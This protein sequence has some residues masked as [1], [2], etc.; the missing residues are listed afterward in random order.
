M[1][2]KPILDLDAPGPYIFRLDGVAWAIT[3]AV[4]PGVFDLRSDGFKYQRI[5]R[6]IELTATE[7]LPAPP[8][9]TPA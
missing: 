8:M 7:L 6:V 9:E 2:E 4:M 1:T 5:P 3:K